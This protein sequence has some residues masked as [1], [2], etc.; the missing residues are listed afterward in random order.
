MQGRAKP[1]SP[2]A[3]DDA[4]GERRRLPYLLFSEV[5]GAEVVAGLLRYVAARERDFSPADIWSR[6]A[7]EKRI[8]RTVRD[9]RF[10]RDLGE[11]EAPL[12]RLLDGI[13]A[14]AVARLG[15]F[16]PAVTPRE[17]EICASGHGGH[18]AGH[19][20]TS[21]ARDRVRVLSCVYYFAVTP[22]V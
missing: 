11:F 20:D 15:L 5:L 8:D 13:A 22:P 21:D 19:I 16:E 17:F 7:G 18:F 3:A 4:A 12:H 2:V 1:A 9:C 6:R 14:S 10:L